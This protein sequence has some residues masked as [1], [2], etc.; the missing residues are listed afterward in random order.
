MNT[1][2]QQTS[3]EET[4]I[5]S[6]IDIKREKNFDEWDEALKQ[7]T[8]KLDLEAKLRALKQVGAELKSDKL[9]TGPLVVTILDDPV[10]I[11]LQRLA[12]LKRQYKNPYPEQELIPPHE[13][14]VLVTKRYVD[15][16]AMELSR[17]PKQADAQRIS[18]LMDAYVYTIV[19][20]NGV[21]ALLVS[22][23]DNELGT[24]PI[25]DSVS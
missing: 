7:T 22:P 20:A 6:Q 15:A 8:R 1:D 9:H 25:Q 23:A 12:C 5:D 14:Y 24:S 10:R 21:P 4:A 2:V 16:I 13:V 19:S 3:D 11:L 17:G 18:E